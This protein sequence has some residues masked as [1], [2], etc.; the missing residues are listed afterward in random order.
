MSPL[1]FTVLCAAFTGLL[2]WGEYRGNKALCWIAKTAASAAFV[3][4]GV[5]A[6]ALESVYGMWV[7]AA[8]IL[9]MAGDLLLIPSGQKFFLAGMGAF[10]AGHGAYV[11]AFLS[12]DAAATPVFVGGAA[13]MTIFA[14]VS[15]RW[16]WP[17]LG[18]FRIPVAGYTTIISIMVATSLLAPAGAIAAIGALAFAISDLAVARDRFVSPGFINRS[19]G[20]PLYYGAQLLLANSI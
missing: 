3:L 11:G 6:G 20:L 1:V 5:A 9:C 19:W 18:A 13:A 16:L 2:L 14:V 12:G 8:L 17:H 15:L 4:A 10:A 7:L